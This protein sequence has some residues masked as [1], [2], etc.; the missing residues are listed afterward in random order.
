MNEKNS[1]GT[2]PP[3]PPTWTETRRHDSKR[4]FRVAALLVSLVALGYLTNIRLFS[5]ESPISDKVPT[6]VH[7]DPL[8]PWES[9]TPS[10]DL[11]WHPCYTLINPSFLCARL[12]VAMDHTRPLA[13]SPDNPK[14]HLALLLLPAQSSPAPPPSSHSAD[15]KPKPNP[16]TPMLLNPGGPG[17]SGVMLALLAG[18]AIQTI[19]GTDQPVLGFDPRGIGF[20]TPTADCWARPPPCDGC[21]EDVA[22]GL[23]H[24]LEWGNLNAAYGLVN[25]SE[26]ALRFLEVGHRGVNE[27]CSRKDGQTKGGVLRWAGTE[28]VARDMVRMVD[29]WEEWV[30]GEEGLEEHGE[31]RGKLVYWGFSY[32]TYLGATFARMFPERV[33]RMLLDGVVDAELYETRVW[34]ESLV[35]AD[36]VLGQFFRYCVEAGTRCDLGREG[37]KAEDVQRRYEAVMERLQTAP[38]TFTHPEHFYPVVLR[39]SLFKM[40]VFTILYS[41]IQGFPLAAT[42]LNYLHEGKYELFGGMFGDAKLLCSLS[43][44]P[45]IMGMLTDAQRSI[46]CNDKQQPVN[47]T[48]PELTSAYEDMASTSQFADIW[49]GIVMQCNGWDLSHPHHVPADPWAAAGKGK[50]QSQIETANPILFLSNTY[51]PVTPLHAAVKMALKF[52]RAGLLEQKSQGHCTTATVSRCTAKVVREYLTTGNLPPPPTGVDADFKGE[53][54]RCGVDEVPWNS[55]GSHEL[56]AWAVEEREVAKGWQDVQRVMARMQRWGVG[57]AGAQRGLD[58]A[59]VMALAKRTT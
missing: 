51:D 39:A 15:S 18:P 16:K 47:M 28:H 24:R 57:G 13:D 46:M 55:V 22:G 42:L 5:H 21:P 30:D 19:V 29:A 37:D 11:A 32:G 34:K 8:N 27:L 38:V 3:H 44:N 59:A 4:R 9:I 35:D 48:L 23:M 53:W 36:K 56:A 52:K 50:G 54:E 45:V 14:V 26:T 10:P 58:M 6:S 49:M 2:L 20:T 43:G 17:G 25:E 1:G 12:T 7:D 41:P 31:M 40:I 33:G